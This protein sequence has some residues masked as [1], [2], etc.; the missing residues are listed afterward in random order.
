VD[1]ESKQRGEA[2]FDI[3]LEVRPMNPT[4]ALS[5]ALVFIGVLAALVGGVAY[6]TYT[7]RRSRRRTQPG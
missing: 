2:S 5:G 4:A 7:A 6:L 1:V 3:P